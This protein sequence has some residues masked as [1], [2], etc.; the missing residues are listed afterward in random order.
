MTNA[1]SPKVLPSVPLSESRAWVAKQLA[2]NERAAQLYH[3]GGDETGEAIARDWMLHLRAITEILDPAKSPP[4]SEGE[5]VNPH[6][7]RVLDLIADY[8]WHYDGRTSFAINVGSLADGKN[9]SEALSAAYAWEH[10]NAYC[11]VA[12]SGSEPRAHPGTP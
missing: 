1:D 5:G 6:A 12:T 7:Q 3:A 2:H 4:L 9:L 8:G 10:A 11:E